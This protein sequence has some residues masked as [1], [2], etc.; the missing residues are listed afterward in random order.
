MPNISL[1]VCYSITYIY[2]CL[3]IKHK[4]FKLY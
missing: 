1:T 3:Y 4:S 2:T